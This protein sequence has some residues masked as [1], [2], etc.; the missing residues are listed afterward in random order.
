[1]IPPHGPNEQTVLGPFPAGAL[2][3]VLAA[4]RNDSTTI[5]LDRRCALSFDRAGRLIRAFWDGRSIRR[6]L[7]DR[8]VEKRKTGPYP[9]SFARRELAPAERLALLDGVVREI[10]AIRD[11]VCGGSSGLPKGEAA[12]L[13]G[14][15]TAVL[16]W[17]PGALDADAAR[18]RSIYLPVPILPPDQYEALVVQVTEGC[19]YNQCAFCRFYRD[20][21]FRAKPASELREHLR[22]VRTFFGAGI[23]LRRSVFLADANALVLSP[24]RLVEAFDLLREELPFGPGALRGVY[25]FIDAFSDAPKSPAHFRSLAER[26]LRRVYLGLETGCDELLQF[27]EKPGSREEAVTLVQTLRAAGVAVGIIVLLGVGGER[28]LERHVALTLATLEAMRL[29]S[30]DIL[31]LSPLTADPDS[32]YRRREREAGMRPLPDA[33]MAAQLSA[34][35]AGLRAGPAGRPKVAV[36]DIRDFLY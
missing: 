14:R 29:G 17:T 24:S 1:M 35:K 12:D 25:S 21:A 19:A 23:S 32:P 33:E 8:F 5:D 6:G 3:S 27:L 16:A 22:A 28:Y 31:Y 15:L 10:S 36:Y 30:N 26:G 13:C 34:I 18:F 20:R 11:R 7:D 2:R 4:L 9:W